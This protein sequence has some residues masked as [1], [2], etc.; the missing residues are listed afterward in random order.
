MGSVIANSL[1][2]QSNLLCERPC[3]LA[4]AFPRSRRYR[5]NQVAVV[6]LSNNNHAYP[7]A[8]GKWSVACGQ[9][10]FNHFDRSLQA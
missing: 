9:D 10:S 3:G 4:S 8:E 6:A 7:M 2:L 5:R 1:S